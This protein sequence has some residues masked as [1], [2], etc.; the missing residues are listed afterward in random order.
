MPHV[1]AGMP[2]AP[3]AGMYDD[4]ET[5]WL[6]LE[7][8][9]NLEP[10]PLRDTLTAVADAWD[11]LPSTWRSWLRWAARTTATIRQ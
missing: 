3:L 10:G 11:E 6:L 9:Y 7:L 1:T 2:R 5:A 4:D 8:A